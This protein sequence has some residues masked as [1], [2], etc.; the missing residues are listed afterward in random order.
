MN[1][2]YDLVLNFNKNLYDFFDWNIDDNIVHIRKI[3]IFKLDNNMYK[4]LK[5]YNVVV[6][7]DFL[8]KISNRCEIFT[9]QN[10]KIINHACLFTNGLEVIAIKFDDNGKSI[11]KSKL[12]LDEEDEILYSIDDFELYSLK[13]KIAEENFSLVFKTRKEDN[14]YKFIDCNLK[15]LRSENIDALK[16]LYYE[17]FNEKND[18]FRKML[19]NINKLLD[20]NW[21]QNYMKVYN[22]FKLI[23]VKEK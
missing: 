16:Y 5:N 6:S 14:I 7:D 12:L 2:V 17:C 15:K 3:P 8:V 9:K 20:E 13:Y 18:D 22:F 1:Y 19:L 10:V 21:E 11:E 4:D 23:T